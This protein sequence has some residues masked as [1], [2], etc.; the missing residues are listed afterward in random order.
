MHVVAAVSLRDASAVKATRTRCS[1][2]SLRDRLS[3]CSRRPNR[4]LLSSLKSLT[5]SLSDV[6]NCYKKETRS[7]RILQEFEN[8]LEDLFYCGYR[9]LRDLRE[10][11][12]RNPNISQCNSNVR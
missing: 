4:D 5:M 11:N 6:K 7:G 9:E 3:F 12:L 10:K 2:S 1:S 8:E